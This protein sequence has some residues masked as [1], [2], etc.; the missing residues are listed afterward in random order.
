MRRFFVVLAA[1]GLVAGGVVNAA[2]TA[3]ASPAIPANVAQGN[4]FA[5]AWAFGPPDVWWVHS[6]KANNWYETNNGNMSVVDPTGS[7]TWQLIKDAGNGKCLTFVQS[8][9]QADEVIDETCNASNPAQGWASASVN[10]YDTTWYFWNHYEV[11][12][13]SCSGGHKAYITGTAAVATLYVECPSTSDG[14]PN[15]DQQYV[16]SAA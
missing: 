2:Q 12:H 11:T 7:G 1:V 10:H 6:S 15:N 14:S 3:T 5:N 13:D 4:Q 9:S 8:G 16:F